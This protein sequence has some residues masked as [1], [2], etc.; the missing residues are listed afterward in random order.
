MF[1]W[2]EIVLLSAA[3]LLLLFRALPFLK[4]YRPLFVGGGVLMII[5]AAFPR[6]GN[7]LGRFLF[8]SA[9]GGLHLPI[10]GFGVVW[11]LLGAW[12]C[13]SL[14]DLALRWTLFPDNDEPH[15]RRL[16]ADLAS[17][18]IY[19]LAFVGILGTV[20][21]EPLSTFL[22]TSGVLAVVLGLAL[23]NTLSDL[24]AGLAINIERPYLAGDWISVT[25]QLSG[26]VI[27]VNWRATRLRNW[28]HD[29]IVIPNSVIA[30]AMVTNHSRP[31]G[32]HRCVVRLQVDVAAAPARVIEALTAAAAGGPHVSAGDIPRAYARGFSDSLVDYEVT[33]AI[34]GF[35][36]TLDAKSAM[37]GRLADALRDHGIAIGAGAREVRILRSRGPPPALETRPGGGAAE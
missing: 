17:G 16:F 2:L 33:F 8:G 4:A 35:A 34:D 27:E 6:A 31:A 36:L 29:M 10:A 23:Q 26:L 14:F 1:G 20:F 15:A 13:K 32:P 28:S 25:E 3:A 30:K 21:K 18:L 11:W 19:V 7:P 5:T 24:F 12:L 9:S 37:I 22:A